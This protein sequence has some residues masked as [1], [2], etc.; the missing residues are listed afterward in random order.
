MCGWYLKVPASFSNEMHGRKSVVD[1]TVVYT[2]A[3]TRSGDTVCAA[4]LQ[5]YF[6]GA[7]DSVATDSVNL[8][9]DD[10]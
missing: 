9:N 7:F 6:P 4:W 8:C 5:V 1:V 3:V 10:F 2:D